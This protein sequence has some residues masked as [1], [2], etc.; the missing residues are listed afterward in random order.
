MPSVTKHEKS[1][2]SSA[3][4]KIR[5][6]RHSNSKGITSTA[7]KAIF[8]FR[9]KATR[10]RGLRRPSQV[11]GLNALEREVFAPTTT[12]RQGSNSVA[13]RRR[14]G[15]DYRLTSLDNTTSLP[16]RSSPGEEHGDQHGGVHKRPPIRTAPSR[17]ECPKFMSHG[18][19]GGPRWLCEVYPDADVPWVTLYLASR[20]RAVEWMKQSPNCASLREVMV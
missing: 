8:F 12:G 4:T 9:K 2:Q 17:A 19:C 6:A 7:Q 3:S 14:S 16:I 10:R 15:K 20:A 5:T 18:P 1:R 13:V 11:H